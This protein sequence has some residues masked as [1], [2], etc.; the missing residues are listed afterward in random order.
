V[1]NRSGP[2][3]RVCEAENKRKLCCSATYC[4]IEMGLVEIGLARALFS[5][6]C[7]AK[8]KK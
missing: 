2:V 8:N 4:S 7:E 3:L 6:V 1:G 5:G